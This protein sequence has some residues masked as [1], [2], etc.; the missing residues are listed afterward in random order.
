VGKQDST[1]N[2]DNLVH[3]LVIILTQMAFSVIIL[4]I[5]K[6][7]MLFNTKPLNEKN[8]SLSKSNLPRVNHVIFK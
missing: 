5:N 6:K 1:C 2:S 4:E 8:N 3:S 7:N